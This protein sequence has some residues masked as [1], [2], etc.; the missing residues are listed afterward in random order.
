MDWWGAEW[1]QGE[2]VGGHGSGPASN[3]GAVE[4]DGGDGEKGHNF[5][6]SI[7]LHGC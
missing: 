5:V 4:S 7:Q 6:G 3:D 2:Q 1:T